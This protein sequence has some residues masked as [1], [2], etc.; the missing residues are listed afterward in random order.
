MLLITQT[1]CRKEE[2]KSVIGGYNSTSLHPSFT[3]LSSSSNERVE[4]LKYDWLCVKAILKHSH[5]YLRFANTSSNGLID[6]RSF[7]IIFQNVE[8]VF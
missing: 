5:S 6:S 4:L 3:L 1:K 7:M 2:K 8:L